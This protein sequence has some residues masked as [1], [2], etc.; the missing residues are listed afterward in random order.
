M[1]MGLVGLAL[2]PLL[3]PIGVFLVAG[4]VGVGIA[5][6]VTA[7]TMAAGTV[8]SWVLG[9]AAVVVLRVL[10]R[11]AGLVRR[12]AGTC[13]R[14]YEISAL[15][16]YRC[17]GAHGDTAMHRD[18]RPGL[19]GVFYRR[20]GC[21]R[22][23]P[24][25][26]VRAARKMTAYCPLC[27]AG[28]HQGAGV[29]TDLRVPVFGAPSSGKTH[30]VMAAIVGLTRGVS[31]S[32]VTLAD[33]HSRRT[34]NAYAQV[35]DSRG[36]ASK[37]DAAHQPIAVTLRF[38]TGK[39]EA[40]LHVYDAAGEALSDPERNAGYQYLDGARTLIFVLDPFA[41]PGIRHRY[42][43]TFDSLFRAANVSADLPEPS[44]QNVATRLRQSGVRTDRRR[45]AF[46]VSKL[47]LIRQLPDLQG[48]S[49]D[50]DQVRAWLL[51]EGMDNLVQSAE[52]DFREVR[53]FAV[54]ATDTTLGRG[55]LAPFGWLLEDEPITLPEQ[56]AAGERLD[57][58]TT[59][60]GGGMP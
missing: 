9:L 3:L 33:E 24:T 59:K 44:Y 36:S 54:S 55:P 11:L 8:F 17:P 45:L 1:S 16:V 57:G 38:R 20:C 37:T 48:L 35:I 30:L 58:E 15:P 34:Y 32:R 28:L 39:R 47:D 29:A 5:L 25:T 52:R 21:G 6:L 60:A 12:S 46:V 49:D 19:L 7:V 31:E 56:R 40:L 50:G 22:R 23:L 18:V 42:Q 41:V 51:G 10:D 4:T 14:C 53:Y 43:R 13:P 27:G 26:V 2:W